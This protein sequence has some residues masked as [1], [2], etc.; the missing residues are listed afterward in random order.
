MIVKAH[1]SEAALYFAPAR[2][3]GAPAQPPGIRVEA[4]QLGVGT[5]GGLKEIVHA[6]SVALQT[7]PFVGPN[8]DPN[9]HPDGWMD[10]Y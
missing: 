2:N 8:T 10:V 4:A 1:K 6:V 5:E 7:H 9:A 3:R